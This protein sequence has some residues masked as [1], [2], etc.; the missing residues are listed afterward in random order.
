MKFKE[1]RPF[2]TTEAAEQKLLQLANAMEPDHAGRLA[3][4]VLNTQFHD[5]G[6]SHEEYGAA[7][8][9]AIAPGWLTM[10]PSGAYLS[11]TQAGAD[12]FARSGP[13]SALHCHGWP[14]TAIAQRILFISLQPTALTAS[15]APVTSNSYGNSEPSAGSKV[16]RKRLAPVSPFTTGLEASPRVMLSGGSDLLYGFV[17]IGGLSSY[18]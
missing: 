11:F 12:L 9:A 2:A 5:A 6:G 8:K 18:W 4:G 3:V 10:H 16:S 14:I 15:G 7:V 17:L 13:R 1:D